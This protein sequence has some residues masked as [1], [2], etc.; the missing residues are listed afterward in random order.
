MTGD[1][2]IATALMVTPLNSAAVG[3]AR[4]KSSNF[5]PVEV[6]MMFPGFRS[7]CTIPARCALSSAY[8]ICAP[9]FSTCSGGSGPFSNL[10]ASVSPSTHSITR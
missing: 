3:L 1:E 5:A 6:S 7:R 9:Y 4:P 8:A 2:R 10:F